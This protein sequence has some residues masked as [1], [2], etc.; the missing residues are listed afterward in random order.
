MVDIACRA[1]VTKQAIAE[2]VVQFEELGLV[3]R[4]SD[5]TDARA[6]LVEFTAPGRAWLAAFGAA[7]N[8]A[9]LEM[10][11]ELGASRLDGLKSA[12]TAYAGAFDPLQCRAW[13]LPR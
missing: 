8:Q 3:K 6:K 13:R 11:E 2:L 7:L 1:G 12:L 9:E 5:P 10:Q 4:V